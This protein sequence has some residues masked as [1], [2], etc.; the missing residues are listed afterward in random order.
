VGWTGL[1][2]ALATATLGGGTALLPAVEVEDIA[3][4]KKAKGGQGTKSEKRPL[5]GN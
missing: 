4:K 5:I 1:F 3:L 2:L